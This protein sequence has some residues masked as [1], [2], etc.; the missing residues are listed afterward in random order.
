[1]WYDV[2]QSVPTYFHTNPIL[3][4]SKSLIDLRQGGPGMKA[5]A[6]YPKKFAKL[7]FQK[8]TAF[9]EE[10]WAGVG[11]PRVTFNFTFHLRKSDISQYY[12]ETTILNTY[13]DNCIL[14]KQFPDDPCHP[15]SI[16][17]RSRISFFN[18][19]PRM[20]HLRQ[21]PHHTVRVQPRISRLGWVAFEAVCK[22]F[23]VLIWSGMTLLFW[24]NA[25]S[26]YFRVGDIVLC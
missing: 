22:A 13:G 14:L 2:S 16:P 6:A 17:T 10:S 12:V 24:H 3:E 15:F 8:H 19:S 11:L 26:H 20:L 25:E 5:S 9:M 1:M 7:V 18:R 23:C 4:H 21:C